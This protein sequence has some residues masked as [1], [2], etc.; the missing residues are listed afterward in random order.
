MSAT[1]ALQ[2]R[3]LVASGGHGVPTTSTRA[4]YIPIPLARVSAIILEGLPLYLRGT[5][6][7]AEGQTEG[8]FAL[9]RSTDVPFTAEDRARLLETGVQFVYIRMAD[10]A[11][12]RKQLEAR[13]D[14]IAA[15]SRVAVSERATIVYETSVELVNELLCDPSAGHFTPRLERIA[16]AIT[17]LVIDDPSAF[18]HLFTASYHDFYT[19]THLVNVAAYMVPLAHALG[20]QGPVQLSE[21]CQA[22]L[23]HDIGK[24]YVPEETLNKPGKLS[25][26]E[27]WL[28]K[29][30]PEMGENHLRQYEGIPSLAITVTRQHHE[31]LDG[32]GYDAGLVADQIHPVSKICAVA[33]CFDAMTAFRPFK[34]RTMSVNEAL[35]AIQNDTPRCYDPRVVAAL[36][37][38]IETTPAPGATT[39]P[40]PPAS[41]PA[42]PERRQSARYHFTCPARLHLLA[43]GSRGW[44]EQRGRQVIAH[45][46]SRSGLGL[47]S[48]FPSKIGEH[49]HV[50]LH[51]RGWNDQFLE[52]LTVRCRQYRDGWYEIGLCLTRTGVVEDAQSGGAES[53]K[54]AAN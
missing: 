16:R 40:T 15:D 7:Q 38:L 50:Y 6:T 5:P 32:S 39:A 24:L 54:P 43:P 41:T 44:V 9:Y 3:E 23:L 17:T 22:G 48:R 8:A 33:D 52:G 34:K 47:L 42:P 46:I 1:A 25:E 36:R 31:R 2:D 49:A 26:E 35:M 12:F 14:Q 4:G 18:T 28:L 27:W 29:R 13:L 53:Q 51:A 10:Q 11:Q 21:I 30:H 45:S 37:G 20:F 19:A